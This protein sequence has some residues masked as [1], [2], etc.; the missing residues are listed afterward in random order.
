MTRTIP[1]LV[2]I[3]ALVGCGASATSTPTSQ[4]TTSAEASPDDWSE[5]GMRRLDPSLRDAVRR[6]T[7]DRVAIK[8]FFRDDP[9]DDELEALLLSRVGNQVIGQV[10]LTTLHRIAHRDDVDRIETL[11][12]VGY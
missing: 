9:S 2:L 5:S 4:D 1:S 8:V 11:Q 3:A 10:Q 7:D 12:D 6:G